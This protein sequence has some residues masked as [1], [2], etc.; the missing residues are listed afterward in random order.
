MIIKMPK[1][2]K[3]EL[4]RVILDQWDPAHKRETAGF[5]FYNYEA[6]EIA[7]RVRKNS[8]LTTIEKAVRESM[9]F[10]LEL[11]HVDETLDPEETRQVARAIQAL[12]KN[13]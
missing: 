12:V 13:M 3:A 9:E 7:Q 5:M 6:D 4:I 1:A 2:T 8:T 10:K 11:E